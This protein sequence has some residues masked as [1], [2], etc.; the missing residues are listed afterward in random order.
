MARARA[1][2]R[3]V[4]WSLRLRVL[5]GSAAPLVRLAAALLLLVGAGLLVRALLAPE[6]PH[7]EREEQARLEPSA[8]VA[9]DVPDVPDVAPPTIDDHVRAVVPDATENGI[10]LTHGKVRL[11]MLEPVLETFEDQDD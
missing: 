1:A 8:P 6:R 11:V 2:G 4:P 3:A 7:G 9:A 5:R 10:V